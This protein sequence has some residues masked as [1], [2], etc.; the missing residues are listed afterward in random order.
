MLSLGVRQLDDIL[1]GGVEEGSSVAF[2]GSIEYDNVILMH[3]AVLEALKAG[4]RVLVVDFRQP[5]STLLKELRNHGIDYEP[6]LDDSLTILD[7]YSNLYGQG[8]Q[9]G[10]NVLPNP[11]D[12]GITTAII[13][14]ALQ[15]DEY[16]ILVIDDVTSQYTLQ[17]SPKIYIKAVVRLVNSVKSLGK[18]TF[19]AVCSDVFEK[20]DLAAILIPFDY[21][22][23]VSKGVV[24]VK[25]SLQPLRVVE[26]KFAYMR[27]RNG[28]SPMKEHY[29]SL[30]GLKAQLRAGE[31]GTIWLKDLRVQILE[32]VTERSLI[33]TVYDFL[34]PEKGKELLYTWGKKQFIGYG[35]YSKRHN[36]SIEEALEDIFK[37]TIAS[38]GGKLE[39]VELSDSVIIIRGTNLFPS[40]KGYPYPFHPNYAGSL[41]QFLTEFTGERWEGEETKCEAMGAEHCEFVLRKVR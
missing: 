27:T 28:I 39:L 16:D 35:E 11:L 41:A 38:G 1:G 36:T 4:K 8:I 3:Q 6:F 19:V 29:Q 31:N 24:E 14:E 32:E 5:P 37:F 40:G 21:V 30:E 22:V 13:R 15:G 2:V 34:G 23:E 17:S 20:S 7:G 25:R 9:G 10:R 26:P 12:L 33:E 18:T